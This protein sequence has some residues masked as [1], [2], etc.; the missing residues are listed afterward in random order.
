MINIDKAIKA[1][2]L[3]D[4]FCSVDDLVA[5][6]KQLA[7][8]NQFVVKEVGVSDKGEPIH[9]IKYG[10]GA[11]KALIV[12]GPH[13]DEPIGS[14]TVYSLLTLLRD[15]N[16]DLL[17]QDVEWNIIPCIDPDG[18]KLNEGWSQKPFSF[19]NFMRFFHKQNLKDQVDGSFPVNYKKLVFDNPVAGA[20]VLKKVI[21]DV[22]PDFYFSLHNTMIGGAHYYISHDIGSTYYQQLYAL[23]DECKMPLHIGS[24]SY[25]FLKE[26]DKAIFELATMRNVYDDMEP[27]VD[28]P[29]DHLNCG[30]TSWEYLQ[31]VNS[32]AFTFVAEL[33][34]VKHPM[35]SVTAETSDNY[36]QLVLRAEADN[37]YL[38]TVILEEWE[39]VKSDVS[40]NSPFYTKVMP[41]IEYA[42][43]TLHEFLPE[44]PNKSS[45][46]TL[47]FQGYKGKAR[48]DQRFNVYMRDRYRY[49]CT[50]YE[51][52]R[53]LKES[54]QTP[55]V[56]SAITRLDGLFDQAFA[57]VFEH[58]RIDDFEVLDVNLLAKAQLGSGLIAL[59]A[60]IDSRC[61]NISE[62]GKV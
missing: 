36:R 43:E 25:P 29:A 34:Y 55:S 21:D 47:F 13:A 23:L 30:A 28:N 45:Q 48:E 2:P 16:V 51:F 7:T 18:A 52:V 1:L 61:N 59:N 37:K 9:H 39:H 49:L 5:L 44:W 35:M 33:A 31:S 22:I 15:K 41:H 60:L 32:N 4:K 57:E 26:F 14:L 12:G 3:F 17:L 19:D 38:K 53:L 10:K 56:V 42:K 54:H 27:L 46:H 50:C 58:I 40:C 20:Q 62:Q 11:I 8:N 6:A 24:P